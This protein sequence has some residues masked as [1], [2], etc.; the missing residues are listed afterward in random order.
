[1][2]Q[3]PEDL[4]QLNAF[5]PGRVHP[6]VVLREISEGQLLSQGVALR[7]GIV[8]VTNFRIVFKT[9]CFGITPFD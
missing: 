7:L 5:L 1:M 8:K 6:A 4:P 2:G 9:G 3:D